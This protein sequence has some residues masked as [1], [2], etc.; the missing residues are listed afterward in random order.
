MTK[1]IERLL[2]II[3]ENKLM[4]NRGD[5]IPSI[6]SNYLESLMLVHIIHLVVTLKQI[7]VTP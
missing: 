7:Y 2:K 5:S 3:K 4:N 6:H 1:Y